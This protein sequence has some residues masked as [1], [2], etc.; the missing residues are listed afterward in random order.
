MSA[1]DTNI[2]YKTSNTF[3]ASIASFPLGLHDVIESCAQ[4]YAKYTTEHRTN[5]SKYEAFSLKPSHGTQRIG[6]H[7][8]EI[9]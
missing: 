1:P 5:W 8:M 3:S 9:D 7:G 6:L 2:Y 4:K